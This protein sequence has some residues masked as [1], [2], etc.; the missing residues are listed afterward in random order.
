[1]D[2]DS[3]TVDN[4]LALKAVANLKMLKSRS[5]SNEFNAKPSNSLNM[6]PNVLPASIVKN[7]S[8]SVSSPRNLE[9]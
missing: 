8:T 3:E 5:S 7:S 6:K 1:M 2:D 4:G 9:R